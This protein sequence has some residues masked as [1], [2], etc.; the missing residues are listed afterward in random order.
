MLSLKALFKKETRYGE[1]LYRINVPSFRVSCLIDKYEDKFLSLTGFPKDTRD[2][3]VEL[4]TRV[5]QDLFK[6]SS[7]SNPYIE[8]LRVKI[9]TRYSHIII[10][11]TDSDHRRITSG[12]LSPGVEIDIEIQP[13][14][15]WKL[16]GHCGI[17]W[18]AVSIKLKN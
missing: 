16:D 15:A 2:Y 14:T 5:S 18:T 13:K 4:E 1:G 11:M 9:P 12:Q 6:G 8:N 10:P 3:V 17:S 7:F